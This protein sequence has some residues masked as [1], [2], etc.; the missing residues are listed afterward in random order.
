MLLI[1]DHTV[2]GLLIGA[3][4]DL[5]SFEDA[6]EDGRVVVVQVLPLKLRLQY[7]HQERQEASADE[8]CPLPW[9]NHHCLIIF[10]FN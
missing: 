7:A 8:P 1:N 3:G 9:I 10:G 4:E 6:L 5:V 2:D